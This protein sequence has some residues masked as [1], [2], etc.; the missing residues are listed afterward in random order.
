MEALQRERNEALKEKN[1]L[2]AKEMENVDLSLLNAQ[3]RIEVDVLKKQQEILQQ[4]M[5]EMGRVVD[6]S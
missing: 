2:K 4:K 6:P 5:Q 1:E 3:L